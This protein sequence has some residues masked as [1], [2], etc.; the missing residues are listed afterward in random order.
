M[1]AYPR[2]LWEYPNRDSS[3]PF[4]MERKYRSI[5]PAYRGD[6]LTLILVL[7]GEGTGR[8]NGAEHPMRR[9]TVTFTL[10]Y[11]IHEY[12]SLTEAPLTIWVCNFDLGLLL[13]SGPGDRGMRELLDEAD[14]GAPYCQLDDDAY[15]E[16]L[17]I[18]EAMADEYDGADRWRSVA[19]RSRLFEA[20]ILFDRSRS[21]ARGRVEGRDAG[22]A[23]PSAQPGR[24]ASIWSVIHYVHQHYADSLTLAELAARFHFNVTHLSERLKQTLGRNYIDFV[25]ELRIRHACGLLASTELPITDIAMEVGF[26]SFSSFSRNFQD[27][28]GMSPS[29]YRKKARQHGSG[30]SRALP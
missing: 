26:G 12:R 22:E 27:I 3:F 21:P 25:R 2:Y 7:E 16:M 29:E 30:S 4:F 18:Y 14:A 28:R 13:P 8:I 19:L 24:A 23:T 6:F 17:R 5:V 15:G 10:P 9:G 20:L 11:Q 1:S